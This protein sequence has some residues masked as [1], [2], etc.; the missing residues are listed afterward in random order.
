MVLRESGMPSEWG[1]CTGLTCRPLRLHGSWTLFDD[2]VRSATL[3]DV[4]DD[5]KLRGCVLLASSRGSVAVIALKEM[6]ELFLLPAARAPLARVF[7]GEQDIMLAFE[8]GKTRVWNVETREFRRSTGFDSAEEMLNSGGWTE[9]QLGTPTPVDDHALTQVTGQTPKGSSD[10]GRLLQLDLRQLGCWLHRLGGDSPLPSL[11]GLLSVFLTF[12]I[13]PSIDE[14]C[15]SNLGIAPASSPAAIGL[16]GPFKTVEVAYAPS[17]AAWR[18]SSAV[19][20]L[21]QLAIV[22][23]L[24]PFLD[25][26]EHESYAADVIAYYSSCLPDNTLEAEL[27]LFAA[28]YLD[29]ATDVHQAARMLFAAQLTRMSSEQIAQLVAEQQGYCECIIDALC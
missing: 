17:A 23:L 13:N 5:H 28:F 20:G 25:S 10:L 21:R 2:P 24:R 14:V 22:T 19:T 4:K 7:L 3:L 11:R 8:N 6:E 29:S 27:E 26:P 18:V 1:P 15:T 16:E 9:V 12:G